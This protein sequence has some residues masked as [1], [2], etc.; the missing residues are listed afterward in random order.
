MALLRKPEPTPSPSPGKAPPGYEYSEDEEYKAISDMV[1]GALGAG[2]SATSPFA[3]KYSDQKAWIGADARG[4]GMSYTQLRMRGYKDKD[5]LIDYD[6]AR[7][8]PLDWD[9][10]TT[11]EFVNLGIVN[12]VPGFDVNMGMPDIQAAWQSMLDSSM[13][14][15][16][17]VKGPEDRM[18]T[19]WDVMRSYSNSKGKFG[20]VQKG[21]WVFDVATGERIKYVGPRTRT[22]TKKEF[23]IS[24]PEEVQTIVTQML[25]E[26]LGRAP[27]ENE[28]AR[29]KA[30]I[31]G[32]EKAHPEV[33][34]V[35]EQLEPDLATGEVT[36]TS[37]TSTTTGGASD[38][39]RA[40]LVQTPMEKTKEY[41]KYQAATTYW[42]A[43]MQMIGGG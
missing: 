3:T 36:P 7:M 19:P 41:G 31:T 30:S 37:Q 28:L 15:N 17:K 13:L 22:S 2:S 11:R 38:A 4:G 34:T 25:R 29:F 14:F 33:T 12:K 16:S 23:D 24:S 26:M 9:N 32:Y 6:K 40:A 10:A 35:T 39:A 42:D 27:N 1:M 8:A 18:W 21:D 43:M 5:L 20:T